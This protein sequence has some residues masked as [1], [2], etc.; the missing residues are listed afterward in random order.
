M[1]IDVAISDYSNA[2]SF[3]PGKELLSI[4]QKAEW[5]SRPFWKAQK[6][7]PLPGFD[8]RRP[9]PVT[10]RYTDCANLILILLC[11]QY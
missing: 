2:I 10:S 6:I 11:N 9:L 8:P 7:S 5:A 4:V 3:T 1:L